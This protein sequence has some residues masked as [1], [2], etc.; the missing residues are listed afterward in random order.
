[1]EG[2]E[3]S[4]LPAERAETSPE[5]I[6]N[7]IL[8]LGSRMSG[9]LSFGDAFQ[10]FVE[11]KGIKNLQ[12]QG[13]RD[14]SFIE[15]VFLGNDNLVEGRR[16]PKLPLGVILFPEMRQYVGTSG[17]SLDT[18]SSGI[19]EFVRELCAKY[20]VPLREVR[21]IGENEQV[22]FEEQARAILERQKAIEN[23]EK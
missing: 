5:Q 23:K 16:N 19:A 3:K 14:A 8:V 11:G 15:H 1:M 21:G 22:T 12:V 2:E 20:N 18:Y 4:G 10:N 9:A 17:M 7:R 6:E 13:L